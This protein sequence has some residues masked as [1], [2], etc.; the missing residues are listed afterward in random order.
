MASRASKLVILLCAG[1]SGATFAVP[2]KI[3]TPAASRGGLGEYAVDGEPGQEGER[4][5]AMDIDRDGAEDELRWSS[6]GSGSFI[7]ADDS[8]ATL[9]LAANH[10]VFALLQQHLH[11]VKFEHRYFVVTGWVESEQGPWHKDVFAITRK[12]FIKVCAFSGKGQGQ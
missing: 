9:T 5:L 12:G 7:P 6:P 2:P 11:V 4:R 10:K 1:A 3:C 8:T